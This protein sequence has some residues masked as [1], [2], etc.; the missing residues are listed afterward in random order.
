MKD[1]ILSTH[2]SDEHRIA[3]IEELLPEA[4]E[5]YKNSTAQP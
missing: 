4:F 5:V 1:Q 2:P 3:Q